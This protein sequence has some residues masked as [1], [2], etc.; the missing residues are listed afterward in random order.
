MHIVFSF[1]PELVKM[2]L[3]HSVFNGATD[4]NLQHEVKVRRR[5]PLL[6]E[7]ERMR[8]T[9]HREEMEVF[10]SFHQTSAI[11]PAHCI[12]WP[13]WNHSRDAGQRA[14]QVGTERQGRPQGE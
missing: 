3:V 7:G 4:N 1:L 9:K 12:T 14:A 13:E 10:A 6:W 8:E 2:G 5:K 11:H